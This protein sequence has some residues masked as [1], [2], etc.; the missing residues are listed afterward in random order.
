[1]GSLLI[2]FHIYSKCHTFWKLN[3][4][5]AIHRLIGIYWQTFFVISIVL[6]LKGMFIYL[7]LGWTQW[8]WW[9]FSFDYTLL[10]PAFSNKSFPEYFSALYITIASFAVDYRYL[11][12]QAHFTVAAFLFDYSERATNNS[13]VTIKLDK[14]NDFDHFILHY[15]GITWNSINHYYFSKIIY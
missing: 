12:G 11:W 7:W 14:I 15:D 5:T 8:V 6:Y 2:E 10:K 4:S 1:M 9:K 3:K 13:K